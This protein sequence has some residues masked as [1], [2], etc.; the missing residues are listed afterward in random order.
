MKAIAR[1]ILL[2]H[3][4]PNYVSRVGRPRLLEL[5]YII[6]R[7]GYVLRTGCQWS[8]LPVHDASW[9]TIYHYFSLWSK[10]HVFE[11][12]FLDILRFYLR[13]RGGVSKNVVVDTSFVKNVW[14]RDCLGK[15]PVDRGRKATKVSAMT[16]DLG[17]PLY[18]LFHPGNKY[19]GKT[20]AHMLQKVDKLFEI[21]GRCL[22]GDKGYDSSRCRDAIRRFGLVD[23]VT[24]KR[25]PTCPSKN[26]TRIVVEHAFSWLDKYR[27]IIMRYDG[28]VCHFRSFHFLAALQ[29]VA[30]R[31]A[32]Y[33]TNTEC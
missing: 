1:N 17:T 23:S 28:L 18:L 5:D 6:D 11:R 21:R 13:R 26:R 20:L 9:K 12:A 27:R 10:K 3:L 30:S 4:Q 24:K 8:N 16:D 29:L 32:S 19:D 33:H 2:H 25:T 14:G 31:C 7:I 15:S 22:F